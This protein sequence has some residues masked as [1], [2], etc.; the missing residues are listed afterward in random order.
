MDDSPVLDFDLTKSYNSS[1]PEL[2]VKRPYRPMVKNKMLISLSHNILDWF[3]NRIC[4]S[5]MCIAVLQLHI[6]F[7][8]DFKPIA[9]IAQQ[10]ID[11]KSI[12]T[13][14]SVVLSVW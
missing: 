3:F 8:Y 4:E 7:E 12:I 1:G 13:I 5:S 6:G 11:E 9:Q 14:P 10:N 2:P